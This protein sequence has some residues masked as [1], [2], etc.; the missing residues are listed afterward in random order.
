MMRGGRTLDDRTLEEIRHVVESR[1]RRITDLIGCSTASRRLQA[2]RCAASAGAGERRATSRNSDTSPMDLLGHPFSWHTE[3]ELVTA[4]PPPGFALRCE[5]R[6]TF[7]PPSGWTAIRDQYVNKR[8]P[9]L[10]Q[11]ACTS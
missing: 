1:I 3:P 8:K 6:G 2:D 7:G 4:Q 10:T 9:L 5:E 11:W